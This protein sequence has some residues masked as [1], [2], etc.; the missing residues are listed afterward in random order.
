MSIRYRFFIA[1][2]I[3]GS[4]VG[5][6]V[7]DQDYRDKIKSII[8]EYLPDSDLFCP[9]QRHP[10]SPL[11][12][13][14]KAREVFFEHIDK[15]RN[16]HALIVYL[17]EASMGSAIEMWEAYHSKGFV[18]TITPMSQNWVV[19]ILSDRI[20]KNIDDFC[21]FVKSGEMKKILDESSHVKK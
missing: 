15:V 7:Y 16:S 20:L 2:I 3:Q 12:E 11:Y 19:R 13:T 1:G 21:D 8:R 10:D 14:E 5:I 18:F 9:V 6:E 17:P 4:K